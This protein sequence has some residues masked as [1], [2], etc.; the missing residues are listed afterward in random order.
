MPGDNHLEVLLSALGL[1]DK[2]FRTFLEWALDE[3]LAAVM[4]SLE[5]LDTNFFAKPDALRQFREILRQRTG[6]D[7]S[8]NDLVKLFDRVR[9]AKKTHYRAPITY[10]EHIRLLWQ[11][12]WKCAM[13]GASPPAVKL[14]ID[15]IVPASLGGSSKRPNLQF[16]CAYHNLHKSNKREVAGPWL[17][18]Q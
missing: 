7:W 12:P 14:H 3:H 9:D 18:L 8:H 15:H 11:V 6:R 10:E 2:S 16:L 1:D 4:V 13:C 5:A 17:D